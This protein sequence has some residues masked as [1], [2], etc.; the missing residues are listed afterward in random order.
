MNLKKALHKLMLFLFLFLVSTSCAKNPTQ[1]EYLLILDYDFHYLRNADFNI[2]L[3]C[4]KIDND[5]LEEFRTLFKNGFERCQE[6]SEKLEIA[7]ICNVKYDIKR[8]YGCY[9]NVGYP[10]GDDM[11]RYLLYIK[12]TIYCHA[13]RGDVLEPSYYAELIFSKY[14]N[15]KQLIASK[16][17]AD[18]K[19]IEEIRSCILHD[20]QKIIWD[21]KENGV[22]GTKIKRK[23]VEGRKDR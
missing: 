23:A 15:N 4:E 21:L 20:V 14:F 12:A 17:E 6:R 13:G 7:N 8:S 3:R 10:W 16:D 22:K 1:K 11:S 2:K 9:Y 19:M 18:V 5:A